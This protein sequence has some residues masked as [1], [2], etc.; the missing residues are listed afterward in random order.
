LA[1][2]EATFASENDKNADI[3]TNTD[4][5][6]SA[7]GAFTAEESLLQDFKD[8]IDEFGLELESVKSL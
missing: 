7:L 8:F 2:W 3:M 6:I 5:N 4:L 1:Q